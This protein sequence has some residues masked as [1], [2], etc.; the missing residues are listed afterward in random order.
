MRVSVLGFAIP[1]VKIQVI[2][3]LTLDGFLPHEDEMLVRWV[4]ENK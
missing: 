3:V 1:L 4:R 2:M